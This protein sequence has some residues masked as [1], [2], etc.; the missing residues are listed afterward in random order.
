M[1]LVVVV[2]VGVVLIFH[3]IFLVL[4]VVGCRVLGIS[5]GWYI[6]RIPRENRIEEEKKKQMSAAAADGTTLFI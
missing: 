4:V 2:L 1:V 3:L 5:I 6:D